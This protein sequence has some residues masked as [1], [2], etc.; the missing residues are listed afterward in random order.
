MKVS[1]VFCFCFELLF[2][3]FYFFY[4][5]L[6]FFVC[7]LFLVDVLLFGFCF[8]SGFYDSVMVVC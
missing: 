7:L 8:V 4:S 3:G 5:L 1:Q 6:V 2:V